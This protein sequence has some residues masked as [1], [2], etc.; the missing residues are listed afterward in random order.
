MPVSVSL[1]GVAT[2]TD[3]AQL[4]TLLVDCVAG[5]AGVGFL[6]PLS[7]D[8]A[9][10]WWTSAL[11]S[12]DILT[13]VARDEGAAVVGCVRLVL[14]TQQNG[15]HRAEVAKLLVSPSARRSGCASA[16]LDALEAWAADHGRSRLVLDTWTDGV[17]QRLYEARGWSVVGVVPDYALTTEGEPAPTTILTKDVGR[18]A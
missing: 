7:R 10:A 3:I 11:T 14:A 17:A 9:H 18:N 1:L 8:D 13:W 5:G 16:L 6:A 15:Q 4:A 2:D 12:R